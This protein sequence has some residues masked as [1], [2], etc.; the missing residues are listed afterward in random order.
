MDQS[1]IQKVKQ[2]CSLTEGL[3][4]LGLKKKQIASELGIFPS[5][6]STLSNNVF[7]SIIKI[8]DSDPQARPKISS[9]FE[10]ANN[11]SEKRTRRDL[12]NYIELLTALK[13]K[14]D[15]AKKNSQQLYIQELIN[16]SSE[17]V[18]KQLVG[19]YEC[20]YISTFG[21]KVKREPFLIK[22]D[23][24]V[25]GLVVQKGNAIGS[26]ILKGFSYITNPYVFTIQ[27]L[28]ENQL[29]QDHFLG[30]F[31]LPPTYKGNLNLMKGIVTSISNA[32]FPISRKVFLK[33]VNEQVDMNIFNKMTTTFY[34]PDET[35]HDCSRILEF[36]RS[37]NSL[38]EYYPIPRPSYGEQ[39]LSLEL[40]IEKMM[41]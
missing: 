37:S 24:N 36:L 6:Y 19:I 7:P 28:E 27:L 9:I 32:Y 34:E 31:I 10:Q 16:N 40:E 4:D 20:F 15:N 35:E 5:A 18:L 13:E 41:G 11:V 39:D 26:S 33:K 25:S 29:N 21:Y 17:S 14:T 38:M 12:S 23:K 30:H 1:F 2:F 8:N 3:Q 22:K